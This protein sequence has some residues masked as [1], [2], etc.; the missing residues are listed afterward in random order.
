VTGAVVVR[1]GVLVRGRV[2]ATD[3]TALEAAP[4]VDPAAADGEA[5]LAA[6]GPRWLA[7]DAVDDGQ[8][9]DVGAGAHCW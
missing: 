4:E 3:V 6:L 7:G 9:V 1:R 2:A 8:R 5:V